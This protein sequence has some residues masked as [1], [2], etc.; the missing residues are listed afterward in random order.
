MRGQTSR[1]KAGRARSRHRWRTARGLAAAGLLLLPTGPATGGEADVIRAK[2]VCNAKSVC[3]FDVT[4]RHADAGW[5]HYADG[6]EVLKEDGALL[7][8]RVLRHP[9]VQ[10]QPF[11]RA[12]AGVAIPP[13]IEKVRIR[14]HDSQHGYGGQE[15]TVELVRP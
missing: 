7:A 6:Y 1:R 4:V 8:K 3:R 15:V 11:T 5:Q 2:A 9:H 14:A 12:L 13:D 10:E